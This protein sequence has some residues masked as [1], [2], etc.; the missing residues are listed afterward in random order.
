MVYRVELAERAGRDL[1]DIYLTTHA[2][3]SERAFT[4]FNGLEQRIYSLERFPERG[5]ITREQKT[6][7][8]LLYGKKPHIYRIIYSVDHSAQVVA[9]LHIRHGAR[10]P[11][12]PKKL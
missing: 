3:S 4:W 10:K 6:L 12:K 7:R 2:D 11:F 9:V 5:P 1:D 8:H